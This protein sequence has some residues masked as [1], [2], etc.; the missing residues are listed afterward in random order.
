MFKKTKNK[1]L[2]TN[3]YVPKFFPSPESCLGMKSIENDYLPPKVYEILHLRHP[4][5]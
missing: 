5:Y 4:I 2:K 1:K 3:F